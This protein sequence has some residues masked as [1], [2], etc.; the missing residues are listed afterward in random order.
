MKLY[1]CND[2]NALTCSTDIVVQYIC[3]PFTHSVNI[4]IPPKLST[5]HI[6]FDIYTVHG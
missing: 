4:L 2:T 1:I 6:F 3:M 5:I